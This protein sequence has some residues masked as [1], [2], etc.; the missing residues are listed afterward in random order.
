MQTE[1]LKFILF[2]I[3]IIRLI[4]LYFDILTWD[5]IISI[6]YLNKQMQNRMLDQLITAT[7][8]DN[9]SKSEQLP[10]HPVSVLLEKYFL[11]LLS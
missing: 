4:I 3:N 5:Y 10:I 2:V 8:S 11:S 9:I 1:V 7:E 6:N